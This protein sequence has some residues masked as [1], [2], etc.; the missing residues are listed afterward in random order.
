MLYVILS[1][2][3]EWGSTKEFGALIVTLAAVG[4]FFCRLAL[5]PLTGYFKISLYKFVNMCLMS[6]VSGSVALYLATPTALL[7]HGIVHG[8]FALFFIPLMT[9]LVT[10]CTQF[11]LSIIRR[12]IAISRMAIAKVF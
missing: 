10:V 7:V 12:G 11:S 1:L 3:M 6:C 8:I 9:P 2:S 4:E 5:F